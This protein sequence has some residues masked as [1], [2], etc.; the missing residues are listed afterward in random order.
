M[1][2]SQ[3]IPAEDIEV[4]RITP[5]NFIASLASKEFF[6]SSQ[7]GGNAKGKDMHCSLDSAA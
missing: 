4:P 7:N 5:T 6:F 1:R 2:K 3:C